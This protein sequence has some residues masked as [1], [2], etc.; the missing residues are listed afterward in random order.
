MRIDRRPATAHRG[1]MPSRRVPFDPYAVLGLEPGATRAEVR[2]AYRR[3]AK[4]IHPDVA[5]GADATGEMARLNRARDQLLA[6]A[7]PG[8]AAPAGNGDPDPAAHPKPR[9]ARTRPAG[10]EDHEAAWPDHWS[11]WNDLPRRPG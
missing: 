11:A 5:D 1:G 2:R 10:T 7:A 4:A 9:R 8:R 3:R 6:K